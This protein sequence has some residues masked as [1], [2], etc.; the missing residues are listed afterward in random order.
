MLNTQSFELSPISKTIQPSEVLQYSNYFKNCLN[1]LAPENSEARQDLL[2][3]LSEMIWTKEAIEEEINQ[4]T[5]ADSLETVLR[6]LRRQIMM[7]LILRDITGRVSLEEV[8]AVMS[9]FA[10]AVIKKTVYVH[11]RELAKRFGVPHSPEGVPQDLLVVGM[12]KLGGKEL[13]VSSDIDLIFFY[14]EDGSCRPTEEFPNQRKELSN[15]EFYERLAKKIIPAISDITYDGFVFRVDMRLRPNGDSGP[16]VG[17]NEMLEEYLVTQGRDWERFAWSKGRVISGPVFAS[18]EQFEIQAKNL[19]TVVRPFVYRKYLDFGAISALTDLHAKIRASTIQRALTGLKNGIN[20]K[21]G[22]GGIREIEFIVQ[23]FQVIRGGRNPGIRQRNTLKALEVLAKEGVMDSDKA[24]QLQKAYVFLRNLEH[25]IQYVD[26]QQTQLLPDDEHIKSKIAAM[27]GLTVEELDSNLKHVNNYVAECFD[28]IFQ[29]KSDE[30]QEIWPIGWEQGREEVKPQLVELLQTKGFSKPDNVASSLLGLTRTR[31]FKVINPA[32]RD[33]LIKLAKKVINTSDSFLPRGSSGISKDEVAERYLQFLEAIAGR[34][35]YVSLLHQYPHAMNKVGRVLATSRW[36]TDYLTR[37]P[38]LLDELL[39]ERI[40]YVDDYTPVDTIG[41]M[42]RTRERL[43]CV[44]ENDQEMRMNLLREAHHARLFKLLIADLEGRFSVERLADHLSALADST[45]EIAIEEAWK[46][47]PGAFREIPRFSIVAYG[48]LGGKELGYASDLDLVF[49]YQDDHPDAEKIYVRFARRL[50]N[51]LTITT[52]SGNL[53]DID[54]RLRPNGESGMLVCSLDSFEKYERNEDG[55]GAWL[56]EYQALTRGRFVA[57]DPE[58]GRAF[59]SIRKEILCMDREPQKTAVEVL[60]MRKRM[61]DGHPNNSQ[62]FDVKHDR[63]GMVDIEFMVQYI[64]LAH[65]R[66]HPEFVNNFG[67]IKLLSMA[68]EAGLLPEGYGLALG[69]A[70]RR[71]RKYQHEF[72]LNAPESM[73]VRAEEEMFSKEIEL[74]RK[75]W[76]LI[77]P[78]KVQQL[79]AEESN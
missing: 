33:R 55:T 40:A 54:M 25:A 39:D 76:N 15:R 44:D 57:G 26:D 38:I 47:V 77:F 70:Y 28:S 20:V 64:V 48:K 50:M 12:G 60:K 61:E 58:I 36:A 7:G 16:I 67:N 17:S 32:A 53:F 30:I 9:E 11:A 4:I 56:W 46:T 2:E 78:Q 35:T 27:M 42:D 75:T 10:E 21:L 68:E 71:Y 24:N 29:T 41:Y 69:D 19:Q 5:D 3:K 34:P 62:L 65:S 63:G 31:A 73:P 59:E 23:T 13:N 6:K 18:P 52:S 74:V 22:R 72:R 37:H 51:W 8:V 79:A 14:D 43:S 1:A 49:L 45:L 66:Q